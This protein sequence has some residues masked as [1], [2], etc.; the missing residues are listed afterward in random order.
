MN[1]LNYDRTDLNSEVWGP[2]G[3]FFAESICLAY[4]DNATE[5]EKEQYKNFF[6]SFPNILPC[7]KCRKHFSDYLKLNPL[8]D[9]VLSS[10]ENLVIWILNAHNNVN[11]IN[12]KKRIQLSDFYEYYNNKYKMD[13]KT[14]TCK[15]KCGLDKPTTNENFGDNI[16]DFKMISIILFGLVISLSLYIF[17]QIQIKNS[18]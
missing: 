16:Y 4:P 9:S 7:T 18:T 5:K 13:V 12:S 11:K 10:K 6:H 2:S 14:E 3:W 15:I 8:S 1:I 17:R